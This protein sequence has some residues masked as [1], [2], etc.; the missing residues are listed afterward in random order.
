MEPFEEVDLLWMS[1]LMVGHLDGLM[2]DAGST[3]QDVDPHSLQPFVTRT[4]WK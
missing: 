2:R 1:L 4:M 3:D